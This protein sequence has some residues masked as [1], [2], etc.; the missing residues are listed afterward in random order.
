MFE[1]ADSLLFHKLVDHITKNGANSVET[2]VSLADVGQPNVIQQDLLY[3]EDGH[4]LAE[5]RSSF[6]DPEA[7]RY[8]FGGKEEI[9][10]L[11]RV[12]FDE[13]ANDP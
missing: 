10:D 8:N 6:H 12:V 5:L 9:D 13:S 1:Q 2:L 11:R 3:D 7:K 4:C